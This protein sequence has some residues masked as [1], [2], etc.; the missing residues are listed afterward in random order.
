MHRSLVQGIKVIFT[1][2]WFIF[3]EVVEWE[4]QR[5]CP[6]EKLCIEGRYAGG[7][8]IGS[9]L[10]MR[11][12]LF[13]VAFAGVPFVDALT[14]MLDPTIPLTTSEWEWNVIFNS[15]FTAGNGEILGRSSTVDNVSI[16]L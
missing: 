8:L 3:V 7:L 11:P 10:N 4:E 6:K 2:S 13:K 14:T 16:Q 15:L 1:R 5:F 9:V 12:D